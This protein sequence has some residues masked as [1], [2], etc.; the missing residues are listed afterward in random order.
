MMAVKLTNM[1]KAT[2]AWSGTLPDWIVVLAEACD[3]DSQSAVARK[4]GKSGSAISQVLSNSYHNGDISNVEKAV[5]WSLMTETV[6]CPVMG[7]IARSICADWQS[8]PFATT[9]SHRIR[10]H[11]ACRAGCPFSHLKEGA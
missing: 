3:R 8:K 9:N 1:E 11:H 2:A 6:N 7:E 5:R 10:M 4:I